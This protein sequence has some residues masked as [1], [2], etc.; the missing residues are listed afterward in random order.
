M[1]FDAESMRIVSTHV[2]EL[3]KA[4]F[5]NECIIAVFD[6]L[7]FQ[8]L[9]ENNISNKRKYDELISYLMSNELLGKQ[10]PKMLNRLNRLNRL[11]NRENYLIDNVEKRSH[12]LVISDS[13]VSVFLLEGLDEIKKI[14]IIHWFINSICSTILIQMFEYGLPLR[15][16][17]EHG[18]CFIQ[19][20]V[21]IGKPFI[22][23]HKKANQLEFSGAVVSNDVYNLLLGKTSN[24]DFDCKMTAAPLK[25]N[26]ENRE[27]CIDWYNKHKKEND[28]RDFVYNSFSMHNKHVSP[29]VM[30]K[31]TNTE[32]MIRGF[33]LDHEKN[34]REND[35]PQSH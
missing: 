31:L 9:I 3:K 1:G 19:E 20:R 16:A 28:I 35:N 14:N 26:P 32:M 22:N 21:V 6:I 17:I 8:A 2:Q 11:Y 15:G 5:S 7:G 13:I 27:V 33:V 12:I 18:E 29:S 4:I 30:A 10:V 34:K 25:L 24:L 23:A